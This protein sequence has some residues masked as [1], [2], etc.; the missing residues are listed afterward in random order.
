MKQPMK[1]FTLVELVIVIA[2]IGILATISI[3]GIGRFQSETRDARRASSASV[4]AEALE[5]YYDDNGEYPSCSAISDSSTDIGKTV[6]KGVDQSTLRAPQAP[7]NQTNSIECSSAGNTLSINGIDFFEYQGDGSPDCNGSGSCLSFVLKYKDETDGQIKT[8]KSRRSTSIATSGSITDL[9]A[10]SHSFT[11]IDLTWSPIQNAASY[12]IQR[13]T[14]SSFTSSVVTF[15]SA[16]NSSTVTGLVAGTT[17]Y[18]RARPVGSGDVGQVWSNTAQAKTL[19]L[20]T[21][22]LTITNN[23]ASQ[24]TASWGAITSAVTYTFQYST[25]STFSPVTTTSGITTTSKVLTGL[26][27]GVT[28]YARVQAVAPDDTS[29]WSSTK[30]FVL[31]I[32]APSATPTVTASL[33]SSNTIARGTAGGS[34]TCTSGTTLQYEIQYNSTNTAT[35][36]SW[37]AWTVVNTRDVSAWQGNKYTFQVRSRCIGS[38]ANSAY[39]ATS[40]PQSV[41]PPISTPTSPGWPLPTEWAAGYN[42]QITYSWS[43]PAGTNIGP[44]GVQAYNNFNPGNVHSTPWIDYWYVGWNAGQFDLYESY[45][46]NYRCMTAYAST[47][48]PSTTTNIHVSCDPSRRSFSSYPRCDNYGQGQAGNGNA[49]F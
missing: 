33:V 21:P 12:D 26:I 7:S 27:P 20:G 14:N 6:L 43:C 23:S 19:E 24:A 40:T 30:S 16:T 36:G 49:N 41:I 38:S 10:V 48:S 25:S 47:W 4:I 28:Y 2:V 31:V 3:I 13:S 32:P 35:A 15:N 1:G 5:K 8:I 42:Y 9:A 34:G 46:G 17:Y 37:S 29:A 22:V 11:T 45:T 44:E 39:S 18:F